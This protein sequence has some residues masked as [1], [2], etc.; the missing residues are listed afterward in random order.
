MYS[1][2]INA[3]AL[4]RSVDV[5][6]EISSFTVLEI[7]SDNIESGAHEHQMFFCFFFVFK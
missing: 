6:Q 1:I 2:I 7:A 3:Q 4:G 5:A